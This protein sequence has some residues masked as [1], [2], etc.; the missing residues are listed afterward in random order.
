MRQIQNILKTYFYFK[1]QPL[2]KVQK[3]QKTSDYLMSRR[4]GA[5][6]EPP[7]GFRLRSNSDYFSQH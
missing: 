1:H 7:I 5:V 2:D 3:I 4:R 6:I